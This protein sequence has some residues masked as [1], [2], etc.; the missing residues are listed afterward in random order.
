MARKRNWN[1]KVAEML[2]KRKGLKYVFR[3]FFDYIFGGQQKED[4]IIYKSLFLTF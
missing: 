4:K 1:M 2:K 3:S